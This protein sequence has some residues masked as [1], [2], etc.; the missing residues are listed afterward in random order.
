MVPLS[1]AT[2]SQDKGIRRGIG[3]SSLNSLQAVPMMGL[4]ERMDRA[5]VNVINGEL[6]PSAGGETYDVIDPSTGQVYAS[7]PLSR[8]E[9]VDRAFDAA[10]TAFESWRDTTPYERSQ[11]IYKLAAAVESRAQEIVDVE[12]RDTGKPKSLTMSEEMY[13]ANEVLTFFAGA[14]RVLEGKSAG[15]YMRGHTSM[16]RREPIGV[17]AQV[18]P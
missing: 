1:R 10:S 3:E 8:E 5:I 13:Q 4:D 7:A 14:A 15:E 2:G 12:S 16:V 11:A 9:D 17:C 18:T 6:V